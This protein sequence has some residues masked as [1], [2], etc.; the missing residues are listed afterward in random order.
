MEVTIG[1]SGR[2]YVPLPIEASRGFPQS[3]PVVFGSRT[4]RFQLYVN[5][6]ASVIQR[7][8]YSYCFDTILSNAIDNV[9]TK[10]VVVSTEGFPTTTPFSVRIEDEVLLVTGIAG[11]SLSVKRGTDSTKATAH[12]SGT[13]VLYVTSILDL[14][15][16][17]AF[18]VAQV[19]IDLLEGEQQPIFSRKVIPTLEYE[20]GDIA[21]NFPQQ[22]IALQNLNGQGNFGSQVTGGI[23]SRW[24]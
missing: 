4:Y 19:A 8:K 7:S 5:V 18:L 22:R 13:P 14:P 24:A 15:Y 1:Q 3:F 10:I 20:A 23:A 17:N 16:P 21:L 11:N 2:S 9:S 12:P 6:P